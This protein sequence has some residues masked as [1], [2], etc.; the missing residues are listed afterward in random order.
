MVNTPVIAARV[1]D[2]SSLRNRAAPQY[3]GH[4]VGAASPALEMEHPIAVAVQEG[5]PFVAPALDPYVVFFKACA[6]AR[7]HEIC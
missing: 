1:T 4:P 5:D 2:D 6:L 3:I 7:R